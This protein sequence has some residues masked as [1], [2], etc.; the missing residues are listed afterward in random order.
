M[1]PAYLGLHA[2][3]CTPAC[4]WGVLTETRHWRGVS[5][6]VGARRYNV[7]PDGFRARR[8]VVFA[9]VPPPHR[10]VHPRA[11][12]ILARRFHRQVL[13]RF[14]FHTFKHANKVLNI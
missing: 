1:L 14:V 4:L 12:H 13:I 2:Q 11:Q 7:D 5:R 8:G 6:H 10:R 3:D 9:G